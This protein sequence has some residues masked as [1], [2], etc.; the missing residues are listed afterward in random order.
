MKRKPSSSETK[1]WHVHDDDTWEWGVVC[2]VCRVPEPVPS[3]GPYFNIRQ[4]Q[5]QNESGISSRME[6]REALGDR[7]DDPKVGRV[8]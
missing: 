7:W 8:S 6:E 5:K 3:P 1:T 4:L 2:E